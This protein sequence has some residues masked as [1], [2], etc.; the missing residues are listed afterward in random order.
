MLTI[1]P[2]ADCVADESPLCEEVV[3]LDF[4]D[5]LGR[6]IFVALDRF[7]REFDRGVAVTDAAAA[8]VVA[9]LY[10]ELIEARRATLRLQ[11]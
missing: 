9:R 3:E 7:G 4:P 1:V 2:S 8:L 6:R 10:D 5:M 11:H